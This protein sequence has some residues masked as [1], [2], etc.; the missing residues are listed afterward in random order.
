MVLFFIV[1]FF[2]R[3]SAASSK[4]DFIF[5]FE[6]VQE[7][8]ADVRYYQRSDFQGVTA[9]I[10]ISGHVREG[11]LFLRS[12]H[13][14]RFA[15]CVLETNCFQV[16]P[17]KYDSESSGIYCHNERFGVTGCVYYDLLRTTFLAANLCQSP[18]EHS[19]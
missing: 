11:K 2:Q 13:S 8:C 10:F 6:D 17:R 14:M 15:Q 7:D 9:A 4:M 19:Q 16:L 1:R 5:G 12:L 18:A 3:Y